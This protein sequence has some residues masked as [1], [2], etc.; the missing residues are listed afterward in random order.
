MKKGTIVS[1]FRKAGM[2]PSDYNVVLK[3]M[4]QY[5]DP[6]EPLP[7][8]ITEENLLSTPK[9]ISHSL[10]A[11]E[12]WQKKLDP[13]LSSPSQRKLHSYFKGIVELFHT[14]ELT[15]NEVLT[16]KAYAKERQKL[17]D[18]GRRYTVGTGPIPHE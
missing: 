10:R 12:E 3:R 5:Q 15:K 16:L 11:G 8:L 18:I 1:A 7:T 2:W 14:A 4:K 13:L 9:T 17:K 6:V